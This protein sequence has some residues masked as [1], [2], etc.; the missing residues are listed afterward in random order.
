MPDM[1]ELDGDSLSKGI[2]TCSDMGRHVDNGIPI[3]NDEIMGQGASLT[4]HLDI[5]AY[6]Q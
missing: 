6:T 3:M 2:L 4:G 1:S 5:I